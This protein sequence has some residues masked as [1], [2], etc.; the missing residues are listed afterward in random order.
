MGYE[1]LTVQQLKADLKSRSLPISGRKDELVKRLEESD[2]ANSNA[3]AE[4]AAADKPQE[5]A[6]VVPADTDQPVGS[7]EPAAAPEDPLSKRAKRFGI[8][9]EGDAKKLREERFNTGDRVHD[10]D[11]QAARAERFGIVTEEKV[12]EQKAAREKRFN[13]ET[14][15]SIDE[16]KRAR[17]ARFSKPSQAAEPAATVDEL[18]GMITKKAK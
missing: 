9:S 12:E 18:E 3:P 1:S 17:E 2:A 7:A 10:K 6:A 15:S 13:I 11:R 16:K 8:V 14:P 4:P 5:E